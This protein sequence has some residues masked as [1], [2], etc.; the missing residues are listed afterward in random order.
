MLESSGSRTLKK[1]AAILRCLLF[2]LFSY[3]VMYC[4]IQ[5]SNVV[6]M[7]TTVLGS[8]LP[9]TDSWAP[10]MM[11]HVARSFANAI[12]GSFELS[13]P[14]NRSLYACDIY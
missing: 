6:W 4:P 13:S 9:T 2:P 3:V 10:R 1:L 11:K 7:F 5:V 8:I 12:D 14:S